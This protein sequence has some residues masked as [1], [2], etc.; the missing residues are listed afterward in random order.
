MIHDIVSIDIGFRNAAWIHMDVNKRVLGW[1]RSEIL[2]PNPYNPAKFQPLVS[3]Q[4]C[5]RYFQLLGTYLPTDL[6]PT[7]LPIYP[8]TYLPPIFLPTSHLP[9]YLHTHLPPY[10]PTT[11]QR[12]LV[13]NTDQGHSKTICSCLNCVVTA[14]H[15]THAYFLQWCTSRS[16]LSAVSRGFARS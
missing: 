3:A 4:N 1:S 5:V 6:L 11:F 2:K 14:N 15:T 8:P 13:K 16:I 9:P 12:H 7:Y 10:P